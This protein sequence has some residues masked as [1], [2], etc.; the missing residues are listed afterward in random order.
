[1]PQ[2]NA[3]STAGQKNRAPFSAFQ[4]TTAR[5]VSFRLKLSSS[6]SSLM[7]TQADLRLTRKSFVLDSEE[8][9]SFKEEKLKPKI[10]L[11]F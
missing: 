4:L 10:V 6:P 5:S 8:L 11:V 7:D 2:G 9:I 3:A 1:M